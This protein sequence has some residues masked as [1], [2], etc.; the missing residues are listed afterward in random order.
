M[1]ILSKHDLPL[2]GDRPY[3]LYAPAVI[4]ASK[5]YTASLEN[6]VNIELRPLS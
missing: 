4:L 5:S 3:V 1:D 6:M 2:I